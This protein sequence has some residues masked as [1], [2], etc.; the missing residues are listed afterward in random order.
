MTIGQLIGRG[1]VSVFG[2]PVNEQ[3]GNHPERSRTFA[4]LNGND[5]QLSGYVVQ[6]LGAYFAQLSSSVFLGA[7]IQYAFEQMLANAKLPLTYNHAPDVMGCLSKLAS[8]GLP[9]SYGLPL[10]PGVD[11]TTLPALNASAAGAQN[12]SALY[13]QLADCADKVQTANTVFAMALVRKFTA[14]IPIG[15]AAKTAGISAIVCISA[16]LTMLAGRFLTTKGNSIE[17]R[18]P[19]IH[20]M[21]CTA[22]L[23]SLDVTRKHLLI[24]GSLNAVFGIIGLI[25]F[26]I[27]TKQEAPDFFDKAPA[28]LNIPPACELLNAGFSEADPRLSAFSQVF[29]PVGLI[30]KCSAATPALTLDEYA[31]LQHGKVSKFKGLEMILWLEMANFIVLFG[32]LSVL[33]FGKYLIQQYREA[34]VP[35]N[36]NLVN[37]Q[38]LE[39]V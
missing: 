18:R 11:F 31:Q 14:E 34:G 2:P 27:T 30:R 12:A 36:P 39:N 3:I 23:K 8:H 29:D 4:T 21:T 10:P 26:A 22:L 13:S 17:N 7:G 1:L 20:L 28:D 32:A 16:G 6:K 33:Q 35:P 15:I 25:I 37:Q 19:F 9:T 38:A 5:F 24:N